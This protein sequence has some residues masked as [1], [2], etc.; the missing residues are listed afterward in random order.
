MSFNSSVFMTIVLPVV[1]IIVMFVPKKLNNLVLLLISVLLY[2]WQE[3]KYVFLIFAIVVLNYIFGILIDK[4]KDNK[5]PLV[6]EGVILNIF[7]LAYFKY[8]GGFLDN[9]FDRWTDISYASIVMPLGLSFIIFQMIGY[10]F[11]VYRNK[12]EASYC[13]WDFLLYGFYFPKII[14]GP[15]TP[16]KEFNEQIKN[17]N[18]TYAMMASG[19]K[20]F[21]IG[22][23][24]KVILASTFSSMIS[25]I[26]STSI[27][28]SWLLILG[29]AFYI[30]FDFAGYSHMAMG[31]SR[32]FGIEL[33]KNFNYP[34]I[35]TS[36]SEFWRRWHMSL[37]TWFRDYVYI[38]LG[39]N[40]VTVKRH[41]INIFAVW[42]LTGIWHGST[43]QFGIWG[44]YFGCLLLLEK[45]AFNDIKKKLPDFMNWLL[46]FIAVLIGWVIFRS[47]SVIESLQFICSMFYG[48]VISSYTSW[49][50]HNY[51]IIIILGFVFALPT[52][53]YISSFMK[54]KL[55]NK[56]DVIEIISLFVVLFLSYAYLIGGTFQSFLYTNF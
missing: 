49:I 51:F 12:A 13:F 53:K 4:S 30:Y 43:L 26:D 41:I 56:S 14:M 22:L 6:I 46:T 34:Y 18:R 47:D 15:I 39:G 36:V 9:V 25:D 17:R 35:S 23:G 19:I 5:K 3:P 44:L 20:L 55:G 24:Q 42:F 52:G 40:R 45:Y 21:I 37:G 10:L 38:P 48:P 8:Y 11:D 54:K 1:L 2:A 32:I 31:L 7:I 33:P 50:F 27:I 29:Y 16:Y 28:D